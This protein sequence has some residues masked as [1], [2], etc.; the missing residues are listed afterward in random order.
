MRKISDLPMIRTTSGGYDNMND[1]SKIEEVLKLFK[2]QR[3]EVIQLMDRHTKQHMIIM[4][5][6]KKLI[7]DLSCNIME[8][9][10]AL[11]LIKTGR[12]KADNISLKVDRHDA[13]RPNPHEV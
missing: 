7:S 12:L 11:K 2:A 3:E 10:T 8:C 1:K 9:E 13:G 5:E 4:K 6:S